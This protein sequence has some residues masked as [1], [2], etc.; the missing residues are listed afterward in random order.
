[1]GLSA[2][3]TLGDEGLTLVL[4]ATNLGD[5]DAPIGLSTHPYLSVGD[6][7][8]LDGWSL[9]LPCAEVL[10]T[11]DRL[12]PRRVAP[13]GTVGLDFRHATLL[14]SAQI[15]HA[16]TSVAFDADGRASASLL[17]ADGSGVRVVWGSAC[18]WVQVYTLHAP[19]TTMHRRA[20]AIE[21]MTCAPDAFNSGQGLI[22]LGPGAATVMSCTIS[23][24][25]G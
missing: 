15:D 16:Y 23:A 6:G 20:V 12:L 21:P 17:G 7:R 25:P 18:R 8:Q 22:V 10:E 4:T 3:Y 13:V 24:V 14:D 5:T 11:D 2:R 1:M 19:G 9:T